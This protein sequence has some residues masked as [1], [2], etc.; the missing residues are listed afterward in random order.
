MNEQI[1]KKSSHTLR[2]QNITRYFTRGKTSTCVLDNI[3][4][5]F[6]AGNSYAITGVSGT[7]KSTLMHII[8]GI[9]KPTR[10][11]VYFDKDN[12]HALEEEE[13]NVFRNKTIG[14]VFQDSHLIKDLSVIENVMLPGLIAG[15]NRDECE[16]HAQMLLDQMQVG[17]KTDEEPRSLSGGQQQRVAIA[18]ALFNRPIFLLA[19]EPTGS[20]DEDTGAAII[21]LLIECTKKWNMGLIVSS[22]DTQVTKVVDHVYQLRH[23]GLH[24][25]EKTSQ[26]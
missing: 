1:T 21:T 26:T 23:H 16:R 17:D 18:R 8:A 5:N 11:T 9:D 6:N 20:L 22:H 14:L 10:G 24:L 4:I 25:A 3:S 12:I 15:K 2:A 7:G 13:Y 19:D